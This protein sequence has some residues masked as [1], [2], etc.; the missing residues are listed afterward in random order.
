MRLAVARV[1]PTFGLRS[2]VSEPPA[3]AAEWLQCGGATKAASGARTQQKR[4][5]YRCFFGLSACYTLEA[6]RGMSPVQCRPI[7]GQF[8]IGGAE[9][10]FFSIVG[11]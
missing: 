8:E 7:V 9:N 10:A 3:F 5:F 11:G 6:E 2:P 4:P 1:W